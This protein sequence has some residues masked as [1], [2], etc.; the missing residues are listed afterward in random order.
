MELKPVLQVKS[1]RSGE[2]IFW[3]WIGGVI[4]QI[5]G[6]PRPKSQIGGVVIGGVP[7][8]VRMLCNVSH[9]MYRLRWFRNFS[10]L[11]QY[12]EHN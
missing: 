11:E 4:G 6:V 9:D 12:L 2:I 1:P 10:I 3:C 5:G 7:K 8:P